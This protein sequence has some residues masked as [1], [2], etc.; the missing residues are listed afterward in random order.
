MF[1]AVLQC[2]KMFFGF[3]NA[4]ENAI[5]VIRNG[6]FQYKCKAKIMEAR[7]TIVKKVVTYEN[8]SAKFS[9]QA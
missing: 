3:R 2:Q 9:L 7:E 4:A 6:E 8:Q 5:G 1:A